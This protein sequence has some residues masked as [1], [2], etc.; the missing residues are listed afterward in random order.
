MEINISEKARE[1]LIQYQGKV[2]RIYS[3]GAG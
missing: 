1:Q 3:D 2:I